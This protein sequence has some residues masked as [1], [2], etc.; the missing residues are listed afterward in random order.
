M[1]ILKVLKHIFKGRFRPYL[2]EGKHRVVPAFEFQ[3]K[4]YFMFDQM[5]EVP[6]GRQMAA[7]TIYAEMDMRVTREYLQDYVKAV[8]KVTS[9]PK[10]I[11]INILVQL[12]MNLKERMELMVMPDFIFKMASVTYFDKDES[13]YRYDFE[14]NKK[15]IA[16]WK[17][18]GQAL[19]FFLKTPIG[20]MIPSLKQQGGI[21]P[22]YLGIAES[23][24]KI[25]QEH[26]TAVLS[27]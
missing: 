18:D 16:A 17:E 25:H 2:I 11:N 15:K 6:T 3:G 20:D 26:L 27:D 7:L 12:N 14:Y 13:P 21:S 1:R 10:R 24:E 19:D 5:E 23:V 9:D 8:E 4:Q 22:M